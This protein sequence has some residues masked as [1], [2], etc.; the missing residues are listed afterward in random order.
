MRLLTG[1]AG[2]VAALALVMVMVVAVP[3]S[4]QTGRM[5]VGGVFGAHVESADFVDGRTP[6]AGIVIGTRLS[7][8]WGI[9]LEAGRPMNQFVRE[10]TAIGIAFPPAGTSPLTPQD[11]ERYGVLQHFTRERSVRSLLSVGVVYQPR[12]HPRWQPRLFAGVVN[13]SVQE[14]FATDVLRLP[15]D[16]DPERLKSVGPTDERHTRNIGGLSL[17]GGL[18]FAVTP[19]LTIAPEFRYDYGS[20]GDEINNSLRSSVRALWSF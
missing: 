18:G 10:S 12:V 7:R 2:T 15:A 4:A 19:R 8:S 14:R 6:A 1:V 5:Y 17:G 16:V 20:I 11:F 9:E 13:K 3:V